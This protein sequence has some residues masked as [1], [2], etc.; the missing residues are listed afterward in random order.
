MAFHDFSDYLIFS[1]TKVVCKLL[2]AEKTRCFPRGIKKIPRKPMILLPEW[3]V[4]TLKTFPRMVVVCLASLIVSCLS[5]IMS[6]YLRNFLHIFHGEFRIS[7]L[8]ISILFYIPC[9][10]KFLSLMEF[11][12]L[13]WETQRVG[14]APIVTHVFQIL[15]YFPTSTRLT[16]YNPHQKKIQYFRGKKYIYSAMAWLDKYK[17]SSNNFRVI[18]I[19]MRYISS[20]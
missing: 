8:H 1:P 20:K 13:P 6:G 3:F 19:D 2:R 14:L 9:L 10:K 7:I 12:K 4:R 18:V 17:L 5:F 11:H 15:K 16:N